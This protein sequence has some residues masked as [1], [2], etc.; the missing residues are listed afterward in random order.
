VTGVIR[1]GATLILTL[2]TLRIVS[3][4]KVVSA[5]C[6]LSSQA[7]RHSRSP[8]QVDVDGHYYLSGCEN[9]NYPSYSY[10]SESYVD[11]E[12]S[13]R[14]LCSLDRNNTLVVPANV[15]VD[16]HYHLSDSENRNSTSYSYYSESYVD[17][18]GSDRRLCPLDRNNTHDEPIK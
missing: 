15:N 1:T 17:R 12:G 7:K 10:Y 5:A 9:R 16:R 11:R 6:V 18:E 2:A 3:T 13:D 4:E 8:C 14:P